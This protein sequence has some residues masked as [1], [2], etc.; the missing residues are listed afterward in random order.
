MV[1]EVH[2]SRRAGAFMVRP[3]RGCG[4]KKARRASQHSPRASTSKKWG[5]VTVNLEPSLSTRKTLLPTKAS[6]DCLQDL[7]T[8]LPNTAWSSIAFRRAKPS[9]EPALL[10]LSIASSPCHLSTFILIPSRLRFSIGSRSR[11]EPQPPLIYPS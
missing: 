5:H 7:N 2:D 1:V 6:I 11:S 8:H 10:L 9:S 3:R 4:H